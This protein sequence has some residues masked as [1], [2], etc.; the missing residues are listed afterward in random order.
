MSIYRKNNDYS[1][2]VASRNLL[3]DGLTRVGK[4][5]RA[6]VN[7]PFFF[8]DKIASRSNGSE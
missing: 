2:P 5:A 4:S 6:R 3:V 1:C 8:E 7:A